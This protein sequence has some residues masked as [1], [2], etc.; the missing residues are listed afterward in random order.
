MR[1]T[2]INTTYG[3]GGAAKSTSRLVSI[4]NKMGHDACM[5]VG[6]MKTCSERAHIFNT[7]EDMALASFCQREGLLDYAFQGSHNL[8][9]HPA[10]S[11]A[12][13]LHFQNLHGGYFNPFSISS[14]SHL[15]PVA[16]TLRDMQSFT[17]HCAHSFEC[18]KWRTG[19]GECPDLTVYPSIKK[20]KT[21]TLWKDKK[22]IYDHSR[23]WI[24]T[25]SE[26]LKNK[27]EKSI[28][29][30]H[31]VSCI[32]NATDTDV[33]TVRD[34]SQARARLGIPQ[35]A[36]VLGSVAAGSP[37]TNP[38]KGGI[39]S[40]AALRFLAEKYPKLIFASIGAEGLPQDI[41]N[42]FHIPHTD[43]EQRLA[44]IY[45]ALDIFLYT[46]IADTCPLVVIE[47]LSCGVPVV[48]F[49][50]GGV[51]ELVRD[52]IDGIIV[53]Y[54]DLT[55]LVQSTTILINRKSVRSAM[56]I[57]ARNGALE[58]F[59]LEIMNKKYESLYCQMLDGVKNSNQP[60]K[61]F[62]LDSIPQY[63]RTPSFIELEK[64]K[65]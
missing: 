56:A 6:S 44:E 22:L 43:D 39:Y 13:V 53:P 36:L 27:V 55:R 8:H 58:R 28:L 14:L 51:P 17:G 20:D 34:K 19:C 61:K 54:K 1:I 3:R 4:Q 65:I 16:W 2:H 30:E 10:V 35:D 18:E 26:W 5:V 49:A 57:N 59:K 32:V 29:Q 21:A 40:L 9:T 12:D 46:S 42:V 23:L 48:S 63:I 62:P 15:K 60:I 50:T 52:G 45:S 64:T 47:A 38:W 11:S 7:L 33:F 41:P 37:L 25:P 31:P 24:V